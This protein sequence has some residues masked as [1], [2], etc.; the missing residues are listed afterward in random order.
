MTDSNELPSLS[1]VAEA[2]RL[3]LSVLLI[4]TTVVSVLAALFF[5]VLTAMVAPP[6]ELR[7]G[8]QWAGL[9]PTYGMIATAVAFTSELIRR[10]FVRER[11]S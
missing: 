8:A 6:P 1:D 3:I 7:A 10:L 4:M 5:F 9:G 2:L 11:R